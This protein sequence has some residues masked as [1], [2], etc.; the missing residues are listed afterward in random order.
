MI[1]HEHKLIFVH[2]PRTG[3]ST[4]ET[5]LGAKPFDLCTYNPRHMVGWSDEYQQHM[6]HAPASLIRKLVG[7][8][9]WG[10]Y[11]KFTIFRPYPDRLASVRRWLFATEGIYGSLE[12][13]IENTGPYLK[14]FTTKPDLRVLLADFSAIADE[15]LDYYMNTDQLTKQ[16]SRFCVDRGLPPYNLT[17]NSTRT[18]QSILQRW[19]SL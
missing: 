18:V 14:L 2:V 19:W 17:T 15:P 7:E 5:H 11:T 10:Q 8:S 12:E 4:V 3:G 16:F 1:S 9:T 13:L 6:Q